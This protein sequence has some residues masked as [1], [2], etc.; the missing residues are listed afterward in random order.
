MADAEFTKRCP[1][2]EAIK[3][4]FEF[5]RAAKSKDGRSGYCIPC[6]KEK[7]VEWQKANPEKKAASDRRQD[8][9]PERLEKMRV[10][11]RK[12]FEAD[13]EG[14][15]KRLS[16]WNAINPGRANDRAAR[17]RKANKEKVAESQKRYHETPA[18][19]HILKIRRAMKLAV[20]R[21]SNIRGPSQVGPQFHRSSWAMLV[22]KFGGCCYCG[23]KEALSVEHLT[24]IS[25]GG[26]NEVGN[27]APACMP[28]N[29]K[30]W[31]ATLEEFAPEM[32]AYIRAIAS[33]I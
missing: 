8:A 6:T 19:R 22:E 3:P 33:S 18:Y 16:D 26:G 1:R 28:C 25:K 27:V 7:A 31:D 29:R 17:Y 12:A 9:K 5:Y 20:K 14:S 2:C 32:A 10:R 30:K 21:V 24:P 23:C 11:K 13:R 15:I 4:H